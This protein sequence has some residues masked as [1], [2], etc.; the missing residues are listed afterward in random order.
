MALDDDDP[1][2]IYRREV[3]NVLPLTQEEASHLFQEARLSG[4]LGEPA[5]RRLIETHLHLVLPVAERYASSGLS[6][7]DLIQEGNLGLMRA[8][9]RYFGADLD[10]FSAHAASSIETFIA[11]A[12]AGSKSH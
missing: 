5:K 4:D 3:D 2:E 10:D 9:E 1:V 8:L 6:M 7:V 11:K 12:A